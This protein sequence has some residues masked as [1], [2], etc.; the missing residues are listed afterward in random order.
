MDSRSWSIGFLL[1]A[2]DLGRAAQD[3]PM[4]RAVIVHLQRDGL[5]GQD[6]DLFHPIADALA[7]HRRRAPAVVHRRVL[8][9]FLAAHLLELLDDRLDLLRLALLRHDDDIVRLDEQEVIEADTRN[10]PVVPHDQ[11]VPAVK[12]Q[13]IA[14]HRVAVRIVRQ[15]IIHRVPRADIMTF[16]CEPSY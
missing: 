9:G 13:H 5:A 14:L 1:A 10:E 4:L 2:R 7:D 8:D 11:R 3:A 16:I 6:A 12:R 15:D